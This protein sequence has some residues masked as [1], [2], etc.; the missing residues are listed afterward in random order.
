MLLATACVSPAFSQDVAVEMHW[1]GLFGAYARHPPP[2][3]PL[4]DVTLFPFGEI[5]RPLIRT[6]KVPAKLGSRFG[7]LFTLSGPKARSAEVHL[8]IHYPPP[9]FSP[10]VDKP[11]VQTTDDR[12]PCFAELPCY[13]GY[14]FQRK[15][16]ILTGEWHMELLINGAPA[17]ETTFVVAEEPQ[18]V[19][20]DAPR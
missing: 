4:P 10:G 11:R 14:S 5:P 17:E 20:N 18:L 7:F 15:D 19:S 2:D 16:E 1:I 13:V 12:M 8:V 3:D 9:G 6:N